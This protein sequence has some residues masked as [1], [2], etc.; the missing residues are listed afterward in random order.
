MPCLYP[1]K[2][3]R[4]RERAATGGWGVTFKIKEAAHD[5]ALYELPCSK[6]IG[7][8]VDRSRSWAVRCMHEAQMHPENCFLTLTYNRDNLPDDYS[9]DIDAYQKFLKRLREHLSPKKIRFFGCAE[10]GSE[11][12]AFPLQPHYHFL[13][14]NYRPTD[15]I[16]HSKNKGKPLYKSP[17]LTKLW[18]YGYHT[19]GELNYQTAA[20]CARYVIKKIGGEAANTHYVR[21]HPITGLL[22]QVKPEFATSSRRDGLG[23]SWLQKY[24]SD[25]Y[26]SGFVV[27]D[28]KQHPVPTFYTRRLAEE[29]Q[30]DLKKRRAD[31]ALK[32]QEDNTTPRRRVREAV[33]QSRISNL[34]RNLK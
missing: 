23:A 7:C 10:Y 19:V 25:I 4:S 2:A 9:V 32:H 30:E 28:G 24:K 15:L 20:Y 21:Q 14:F 16:L 11:E 29:E 1:L 8:R 3:Y 18:P 13:I 5:R 31:H 33:L 17:A 27:V 6:C 22:H 12:G 34:K 26:P